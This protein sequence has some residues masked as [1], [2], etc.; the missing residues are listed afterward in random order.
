M[1]ILWMQAGDRP[2]WA[3]KGL[4]MTDTEQAAPGLSD[5]QLQ[6]VI[7]LLR[8]ADT[9]ELK[10]TV[11]DDGQRGWRST[12][13]ALGMDPMD[14]FLRQVFFFDTPDLALDS[15][16]VVVRARRTQGK[17]DD[18]V[19]KLRPV[20]PSE[21][22]TGVREH[23]SFGVEVDALPGGFVCSGSFKREL[24]TDVVRPIISDGGK[25]SE[26]FGKRQ[27][28]FYAEHAPEGIGLDDLSVLGPVLVL[29]LKFSPGGY[30][31]R[32][33][34]ELWLYPDGSRILELST[35]CRPSEAF[36]VAAETRAYLSGLG[37]DMFGEQQTKTRTALE[38]FAEGLE[39]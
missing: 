3:K 37:V 36:R 31:R 2:I 1:D 15:A 34:A 5:A 12:V 20:I 17:P 19:V 21:L 39:V 28:R 6:K 38:F 11:P 13:V 10:L 23:K 22:P 25:L 16:G 4:R 29:K 18:S 30:E 14:A 33:V 35:K 32:L 24:G 7:G 26:L 9:T 27:R 8:D